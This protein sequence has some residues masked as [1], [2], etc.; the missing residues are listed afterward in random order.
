MDNVKWPI[1]TKCAYWNEFE[2]YILTN[3]MLNKLYSFYTFKK[4]CYWEFDKI[5]S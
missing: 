2:I 4:I 5:N 3:K 1:N